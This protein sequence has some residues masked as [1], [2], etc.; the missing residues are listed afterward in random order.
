[1]WIRA[2]RAHFFAPFQLQVTAMMLTGLVDNFTPDDT[3][4]GVLPFYHIL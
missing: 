1:M 3:H 2:Q 4:I